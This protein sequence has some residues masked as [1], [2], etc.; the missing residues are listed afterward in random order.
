[1]PILIEQEPEELFS[2]P[3]EKCIF[4][5]VETRFWNVECNK[6]VCTTCAESLEQSDV[7]AHEYDL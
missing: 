1:M 6:P 7:E 5:N 4:C 3:A 2:A